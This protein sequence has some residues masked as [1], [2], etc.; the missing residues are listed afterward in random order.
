MYFKDIVGQ[1]KVKKELITQVKT[2]RIP[3]NQ[4]F[5][6][7]SGVGAYELALAYTRYINCEN[8][9]EEDA[10]G[11]CSSCI[12]MNKLVHPDVHFIFPTIKQL[13]SK[14]YIKEWRD[15]VLTT[16]YFIID[17]WL[18]YIN[19]Q[20]SQAIIYQKDTKELIKEIALKSVEGKYKIAIIWLPERLNITG[21]NRL[22][23]LF[24][25]PPK[26][27]AFIMVS[28]NPDQIL[29]TILSRA[30]EVEIPNL[31]EAEIA[32]YLSFNYGVSPQQSVSIA[33]S[34]NGSL[35]KAI[36]AISIHED[37]ALF[38][39]SFIN[40]MR[41][42]Y[43]RKVKDI[44]IWS[45]DIAKFGREKQ[46]QFLSYCQYM[47]RENFINNFNQA[48]LNYFNLEEK[49]FSSNFARFINEN[50]VVQIMN[51]LDLAQRHIEQ[52]ANARIVLFDLA[53]KLI[54]LIKQ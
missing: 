20:N 34:A 36:Q 21:A 24:E 22:L 30:Q 3:H 50:N 43:A 31:T 47:I 6:S 51:E 17:Q 4:L 41:F 19:A 2:G 42:A 26:N 39:Q 38:L 54:V 29:P 46:K 32:N 48:N 53:L 10:C 44:K 14:E 16:P 37:K 25:E 12:K 5:S 28:E 35:N 18:D 45:E 23:K 13:T 11:H 15:F 8:P 27:T 7:N 40:I 1:S 49:Q 9:S 33:H 52:N